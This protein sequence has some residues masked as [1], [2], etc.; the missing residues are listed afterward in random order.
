LEAAEQ[1]KRAK[2]EEAR[3][4]AAEKKQA[5]LEKKEKAKEEGAKAAPMSAVQKQKMA[6]ESKMAANPNSES[7]ARKALAAQKEKQAQ[8]K[9]NQAANT[10]GGFQQVS[11][12]TQGSTSGEWA[13]TV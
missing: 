3:K 6:I 7:L 4:A 8:M 13:N 10:S 9:L 2:K 1:V 12:R 11:G 5:L